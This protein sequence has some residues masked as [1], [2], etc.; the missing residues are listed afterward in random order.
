MGSIIEE[1]QKSRRRIKFKI[2]KKSIIV[3]IVLFLLATGASAYFNR[4]QETNTIKEQKEWTVKQGDLAVAIEA[5]G[6]VVAEDGVELSFSVS[7]DN[8]EIEE[9]FVK[10]GD[11]VLK[12]DK[13][14]TVK[15]ETLELNV[16]NAYAS[17]LASLA[18]YND[19]MNGATEKQKSD[20]LDKITSAEIALE[21]SKISLANTE[22]SAADSIRT[23]EKNLEDNQDTL[24][25]KDVKDA[26]E[27]LIETIKSI[28]IS[29]EDILRDS[30]EVLGID[31]TD[32]NKDYKYAIGASNTAILNKVKLTY[33]QASAELKKLDSLIINLNIY[34]PY[35]DIDLASSKASEILSI[36]EEHLY[37]M[38]GTLEASIINSEFTQSELNSFIS[39]IA[40]NRNTIN[41]KITTLNTKI[42]DVDDAMESLEDYVIDYQNTIADAER[43]IANAEASLHSKELSLE[44]AKRDYQD[45]IAPLTEAEKNAAYSKL[46][47]ASISLEKA[48]LDLNQAT[49]VS[50]IDGEVAMLN[51]KTGDIIVNKSTSDPVAVI[52]NNDTL[53]IEVKIE[54]ADINNIKVG[55]KANVTFDSLDDL[56]LSGEVSFISLTSET[57]N[58]GIVTYLVRIV[59]NDKG[60][61]QIREGMTAFVNFITAG[62][63]N[64]L[65]IPVS[66]VSNVNNQ[67]SVMNESGE[68]ISVVT[69][70]TDGKNVEVISGL[71]VG[72]KIIY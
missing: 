34:S 68:W 46:T 57:N 35:S 29:L 18:D 6:K 8:L 37:Y 19:T 24:T 40:S 21:Q 65:I 48:Q 45:L 60:D 15:T 38:N 22:Q 54:E 52:I 2:N 62:A 61:V 42:K 25:S 26:Y 39:T 71:K 51:Y 14:A 49:I 55:Q 64:V 47:S 9:V 43:S 63:D 32:I 13:I 11:R 36:F 5:D 12:G 44:Q 59:I 58:S 66:A 4:N 31:N 33:N 56:E 28:N 69:G 1:S 67:P 20:A 23:A 70:F 41:T 27:S 16:R 7:G 72:D 30:D 50:P 53:F 10:E 3:F 17:Y